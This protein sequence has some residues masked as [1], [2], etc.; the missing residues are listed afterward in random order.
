MDGD[1]IVWGQ[2]GTATTSCGARPTA[3]NI[4]WG[5]ADGDNIVWG[6]HA[7]DNLVALSSGRLF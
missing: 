2:P 7:G 4:V 6:S 3:T 1:N 5:T